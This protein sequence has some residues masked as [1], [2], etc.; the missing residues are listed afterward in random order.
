MCIF[1]FFQFFPNPELT[2]CK[3]SGAAD[4]L[5]N[6]N[7][8]MSSL[9]W[10]CGPRLDPNLY[11]YESLLKHSSVVMTISWKKSHHIG[12]TLLGF[13]WK[14]VL[15][16]C[17]PLRLCSNVCLWNHLFDRPRAGFKLLSLTGFG[18]FHQIKGMT[19]SSLQTPN[20]QLRQGVRLST[21]SGWPNLRLLL[22]A[23]WAAW[24][25]RD[26]PV[27]WKASLWCET[28]AS[29]SYWW[30]SRVVTADTRFHLYKETS[31]QEGVGVC[32]ISRLHLDKVPLTAVINW[33]CC[34]VS[35]WIPG[36]SIPWVVLVICLI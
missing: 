7:T 2:H 34:F 22:P 10:L 20:S 26:F 12:M 21:L 29:L 9:S 28:E 33:R 15:W 31:T 35:Q 16:I 6:Q 11:F 1:F 27:L 32:V 14:C 18:L 17:A 25:H 23:A 19:F 24:C 13:I 5:I 8:Q 30:W 4:M 36:G 3:P